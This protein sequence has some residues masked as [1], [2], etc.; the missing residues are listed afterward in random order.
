MNHTTDCTAHLALSI[1]GKVK[2]E[3]SHVHLIG[4]E[5]RL[6]IELEKLQYK[7][8]LMNKPGYIGIEISENGKN[9][10][11][12]VIQSCSFDPIM[13]KT[14]LVTHSIMNKHQVTYS[15]D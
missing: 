7:F 13:L 5:N 8:E 3:T 9:V 6:L 11:S 1:F 10:C 4:T 14:Y 2:S 12:E 15:I